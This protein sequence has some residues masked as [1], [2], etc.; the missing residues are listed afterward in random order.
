MLVH[1]QIENS[2]D[3]IKINEI[4]SPPPG[5]AKFGQTQKEE[6][7][8]QREDFLIITNISNVKVK[9]SVVPI[10]C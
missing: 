9:F 1:I 8:K 5:E 7:L 3:S 4:K 10:L 6:S 2:Y